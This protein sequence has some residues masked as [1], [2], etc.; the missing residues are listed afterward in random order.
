VIRR[1]IER[2]FELMKDVVSRVAASGR[3]GVL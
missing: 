3:V 1:D 2:Y